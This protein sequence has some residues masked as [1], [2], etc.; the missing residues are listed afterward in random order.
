MKRL[1]SS[2]YR[3]FELVRGQ[4]EPDELARNRVAHALSVKIAS[5]AGAMATGASVA[6]SATLGAIAAKSTLVVGITGTLVAAGWLATRPP[7]PAAPPPMAARPQAAVVAQAT[8]VVE[9]EPTS[10]APAPAPEATKAAGRV[11]ASRKLVRSVSQPEASTVVSRAEDELRPETE[12]L[13][14]AQQALRDKMP[15]QALKLLDAQDLRF[16]DG[17]LNQERAAMRV[18]ALCQAGQVDEARVRAVRFEQLWP[19][20]ALLGRVRSACWAP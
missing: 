5:G 19:R 7:R 13:R 2:A 15:L 16:R 11:S 18:L 17:L 8:P 10:V 14:L 6:K 9:E 20:S 4:D 1:S 12:A 3:L